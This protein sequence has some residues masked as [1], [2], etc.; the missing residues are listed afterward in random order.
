MTIEPPVNKVVNKV[1]F[2][3]RQNV[4]VNNSGVG[5]STKSVATCHKCGKKGHMKNNG[6]SNR[7][8]SDW[9]L[10]ERSTQKLPNW[11]TKKPM[12]SDVEYMTTATTNRNKK[13]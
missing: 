7:N 11:V 3:S 10:S 13:K 12:I 4:K 9:E 6:K 8:G 5:S 1:Y 2:K